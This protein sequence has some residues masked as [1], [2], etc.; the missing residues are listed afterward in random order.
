MLWG[1]C[2]WDWSKALVLW[3]SGDTSHL[4]MTVFLSTRHHGRPPRQLNRPMCTD[5]VPWGRT[6]LLSASRLSAC[7]LSVEHYMVLVSGSLLTKHCLWMANS[8]PVNIPRSSLS[9][10][11]TPR[12]NR[13]RE[14]TQAR[15]RE[16]VVSTP[17][18]KAPHIPSKL[19]KWD[20]LIYWMCSNS[21]SV[22][23][24]NVFLWSKHLV[25][26]Q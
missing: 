3:S 14:W 5:P 20:F 6:C 15:T 26:A 10:A 18:S 8:S 22:T 24:N 9:Q 25:N 23:Q 2:H 7:Y 4:G 11:H 1:Q 16:V 19:R 13:T 12:H 17:R 21:Y